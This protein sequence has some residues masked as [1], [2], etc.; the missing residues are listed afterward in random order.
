MCN[1]SKYPI[2]CERQ[3]RWHVSPGIMDY[4]K[5][6]KPSFKYVVQKVLSKEVIVMSQHVFK[7]R[8]YSC[9]YYVFITC[10]YM[11][12][13]STKGCDLCYLSNAFYI[14]QLPYISIFLA[15][16]TT[17]ILLFCTSFLFWFSVYLVIGDVIHVSWLWQNIKQ[18][19][20]T[21]CCLM[22]SVS[23]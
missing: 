12:S 10:Y 11:W 21:P 1:V 19:Y 5:K 18:D 23:L 17:F 20:V 22:Y 6:T 14:P 13:Y 16:Q 2:K 4:W 8:G 15:R 9:R 3:M 7:Q